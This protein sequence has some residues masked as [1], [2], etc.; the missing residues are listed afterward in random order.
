MTD[1]NLQEL[2]CPRCG[3]ELEPLGEGN[4][5]CMSCDRKLISQTLTRYKSVLSALDE[6]RREDVNRLKRKMWKA[7]HQEN[8]FN[9]ELQHICEKILELVDRDIYAEFYLATCK[10]DPTDL[11]ECLSD[12]DVKEHAEDLP[13]FLNYLITALKS[14]WLLPVADLI[15]RA[16]TGSEK[17]VYWQ[18]KYCKKAE[19]VEDDIFNPRINRDIFVAYS[20][21][22]MLAVE[23]LVNILEE[24]GFT[25]FLAARNLQHGSGAADKYYVDIETALEHCK[26][27]VFVSSSNSRNARCDVYKCEMPYVEKHLRE[28]PRVEYLLEPY[29]GKAIE[30]NFKDF[31]NGLDWCETPN[32]V[33]KRVLEHLRGA[34]RSDALNNAI[35]NVKSSI[36]KKAWSNADLHC[37]NALAI[38]P[39]NGQVYLYQL[40]IRLRVT[41]AS[42]I[43][44]AKTPLDGM[45]EYQNAICYVD[46]KTA[47]IL[48]QYNRAI[49]E[50]LGPGVDPPSGLDE[51]DI[52]IQNAGA[53]IQKQDWS[54]ATLHCEKVLAHS[55]Q[56]RLAH[57]Y[58]L[59][60]KLQVTD[61]AQIMNA[62]TPLDDMPEYKNA[63]HYS[64]KKTV[65]LLKH[66]NRSIKERISQIGKIESDKLK[67]FNALSKERARLQKDI[68]KKQDAVQSIEDPKKLR[69]ACILD[70]ILTASVIGVFTVAITS[71]DFFSWFIF[72]ALSIL[73]AERGS[74]ILKKVGWNST[75]LICINFFIPIPDLMVMAKCNQHTS[76]LKQLQDQTIKLQNIENQLQS[77]RTALVDANRQSG[78]TQFVHT[79]CP[80][81]KNDSQKVLKGGQC[82]CSLC[83]YSFP[84][85]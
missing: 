81:C 35:Q 5:R 3:G 48:K 76:M 42:Q 59:M 73:H 67:S 13:D 84:L 55:P 16:Y 32:K 20:G 80:S 39:Q 78:N 33:A 64:D 83:N 15:D 30:Q 77:V 24:N 8:V 10:S 17:R 62:R 26:V 22:D 31:F 54:K 65:E 27:F 6:Q 29:C 9:M 57:L 70:I 14:E 51:I 7:A 56:H 50:R 1:L 18:D 44:N 49:I 63:I 72:I 21:K 82:Y 58:K 38:D 71:D 36:E 28:M 19:L 2:T 47:E 66:Y 41:E 52:E 23:K 45:P 68:S 34:S 25:C 12:I 60:I 75:L 37:K 40:M 69:N 11:I 46:P 74:T 61:E 4:Y 43:I 53:A 79:V 85:Q